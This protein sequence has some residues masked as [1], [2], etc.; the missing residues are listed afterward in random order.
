[1]LLCSSRPGQQQEPPGDG[2]QP[3]PQQTAAAGEL[4]AIA[5]VGTAQAAMAIGRRAAT[6]AR[7]SLDDVVVVQLV[8]HGQ[9][10]QICS[11]RSA[12]RDGGEEAL[13][14]AALVLLVG[15]GHIYAVAFEK[16]GALQK[17]KWIN[18]SVRSASNKLQH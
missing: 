15:F 8:Q 5:A 4:V 14:L 3:Q 7:C 1:M 17:R 10:T 6:A 2:A 12:L 9:L 18:I 11:G 13:W 16:L